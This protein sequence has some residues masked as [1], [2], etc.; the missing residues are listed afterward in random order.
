MKPTLLLM[1]LAAVLLVA[2]GCTQSAAPAAGQNTPVV[3]ETTAIAPVSPAEGRVIAAY[4]YL[5]PDPNDDTYNLVMAAKDQIPWTKINRL[6]IGFATVNEGVLTDL[7][8]GSSADDATRRAEMQRR[9]REIVALCRENNP[10][11]EIFITS[12]FDEKE[13][14][15]QYL[16]AAQDPQKF[17]DS[18]L[19]YL[20][21]Y[22][23]DGYDMD[24][25]SHQ[26]DDYAPQLTSLLSA[27][28]ATFAAAGNNPHGRP[29]LLTYTVW[30]GVESPQT[31][32]ATQDSVDQINIM[33]YGT[34]DKYDLA[35]YADSYAAAGFPYGKMI[36][37]VESES[38]YTDNVG[39]DTQATVAAKC[40]Y[41]KEH[42]LAG[43]FEWRIDNDMRPDSG[44]PT[45]QVTGWMS[46]CLSQ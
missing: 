43:L 12:N 11:A 38:G 13:L 2:A 9:I 26:I 36:G 37:G 28:H 32:A 25:E 39:P 6:Y 20:K 30:P 41:V 10:N 24:W 44:A 17:A 40:A 34:G 7:P 15:P 27:C 23:L 5:Y 16:Q 1:I 42:N 21:A 22:D 14:D 35:S 19:A 8:T 33:S 31:V 46:D 18:A 4:W 45:Y 3:S 29:Y